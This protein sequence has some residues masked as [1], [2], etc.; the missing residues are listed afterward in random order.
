MN[1]SAESVGAVEF[2]EIRDLFT[3]FYYVKAISSIKG[4]DLA[5]FS[6]EYLSARKRI[7]CIYKRGTSV[8][9]ASVFAIALILTC[10]ANWIF[11]TPI[12]YLPAMLAGFTWFFGVALI[13]SIASYLV[14]NR[15]SHWKASPEGGLVIRRLRD[16]FLGA[17]M[18][19]ANRKLQV[20]KAESVENLMSRVRHGEDQEA[21]L[22]ETCEIGLWLAYHSPRKQFRSM[23]TALHEMKVTDRS[24]QWFAAMVPPPK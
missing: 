24:E 1:E 6:S 22:T 15:R 18:I 17:A 7:P 12:G 14:Y 8:R 21:T 19:I 13:V 16:G 4:Y 20:G 9:F 10:L 2:V 11:R 3:E 5:K 23:L